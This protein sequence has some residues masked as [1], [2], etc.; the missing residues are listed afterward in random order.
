LYFPTYRY[1]PTSFIFIFSGPQANLI[2]PLLPKNETMVALKLE[3]SVLMY[4]IPSVR[5]A[6]KGEREQHLPKHMG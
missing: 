5:L 6:Y 3:G 4:I 1:L 2:G